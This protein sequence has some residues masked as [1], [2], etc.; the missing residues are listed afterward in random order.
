MEWT[1]FKSGVNVSL[2]AGGVGIGVVDEG[3]AI[4]MSVVVGVSGKSGSDGWLWVPLSCVP[5]S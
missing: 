3:G 5:R 4:W 1:V 2:L